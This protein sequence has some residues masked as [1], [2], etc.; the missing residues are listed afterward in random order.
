MNKHLYLAFSLL[1]CITTISPAGI[2]DWFDF[3][4]STQSKGQTV[5]VQ[6]AA[7]AQQKKVQN[8]AALKS[9]NKE[10]H[11]VTAQSAGKT[12]EGAC[13]PCTL[14]STAAG[15]VA[16]PFALIGSTFNVIKNNP[17]YTALAVLGVLTVGGV[18]YIALQD[19]DELDTARNHEYGF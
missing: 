2:I 16:A 12:D 8:E 11:N 18:V 13:V 6:E 15:I 4:D 1:L 9:V 3:G 17:G 10:I 7:N 14:C 19:E 5:L